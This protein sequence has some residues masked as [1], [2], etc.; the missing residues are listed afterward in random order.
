MAVASGNAVNRT[1]LRWWI[2]VH[3]PADSLV[4]LFSSDLKYGIPNAA[5]GRQIASHV[6]TGSIAVA[7]ASYLFGRNEN[8]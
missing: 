7:W 2:T 6:Q 1:G 5:L 3:Y 8:G 4:G